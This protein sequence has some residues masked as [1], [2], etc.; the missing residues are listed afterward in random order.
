[1]KKSPLSRMNGSQSYSSPL[2]NRNSGGNRNNSQNPNRII[3][4]NFRS[5]NQAGNYQEIQNSGSNFIPFQTSSPMSQRN[6]SGNWQGS[7]GSYSGGYNNRRNNFHNSPGSNQSSPYSPFKNSSRQNYGKKN[8]QKNSPRNIDIKAYLDVKSIF[9]NPWAEFEV[10]LNNAKSE[11]DSKILENES[12]EDSKLE[13]SSVSADSVSDCLTDRTLDISD[14]SQ[15]IK[16][17]PEES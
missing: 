12:L 4:D 17:S 5:D 10:E 8:Y 2:G 14:L 13:S 16:P 9:E 7:G 11:N 15:D 1:M 3:Y 6:N